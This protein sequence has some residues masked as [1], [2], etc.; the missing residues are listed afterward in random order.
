MSHIAP[1]TLP[2]HRSVAGGSAGFALHT[3]LPPSSWHVLPV[4]HIA[5]ATLPSHR[6]VTGGSA[7]F[8]LHTSLPLSS[9]H[10]LPVSHVAPATLPAHKSVAGGSAGFALHTSF[11]PSSWHVL[12]VSHVAP[13]T[14]PAHRS[15]AGGAGGLF[16]VDEESSSLHADIANSVAIAIEMSILCRILTDSYG[17]KQETHAPRSCLCIAQI[18]VF[19]TKL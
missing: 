19:G 14:L 9:W 18:F 3:S 2:S 1:A 16:G 8:V 4:S 12:P 17:L 13:A 7:G 10:V 11:P 6:S 5:P 15:V